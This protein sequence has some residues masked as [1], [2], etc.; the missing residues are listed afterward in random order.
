M[1]SFATASRRVRERGWCSVKSPR[2]VSIGKAVSYPAQ[3]PG[4]TTR[5]LN[6]RHSPAERIHFEE[7]AEV[8]GKRYALDVMPEQSGEGHVIGPGIPSTYTAVVEFSPDEFVRIKGGQS[9]LRLRG[10]FSYGDA[11]SIHRL[12]G[13]QRAC[14][15]R[16]RMDVL[17]RRE[18]H[19]VGPA[20]KLTAT[21]THPHSPA[22]A[23]A[24]STCRSASAAAAS[25]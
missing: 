24:P 11:F 20:V 14:C 5:V 2:K 21:R 19:Q 22:P 16:E 9:Q 12:L 17:R 3:S 18:L 10:T 8:D 4:R 1:E 13:L 25:E 7:W 15:R 6:A 23:A